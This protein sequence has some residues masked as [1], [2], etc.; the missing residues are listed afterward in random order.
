LSLCLL[1]FSR[2]ICSTHLSSQAR[3]KEREKEG[4]KEGKQVARSRTATVSSK[5]PCKILIKKARK[6]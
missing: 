1:L 2:V 6:P 5:S 4:R 3:N